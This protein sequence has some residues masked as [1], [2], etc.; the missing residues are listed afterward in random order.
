MPWAESRVVSGLADSWADIVF[1]QS[2]LGGALFLEH[3]T[4]G[5][6]DRRRGRA[7][8]GV[9]PV[10]R[11]LGRRVGPRLRLRPPFCPVRVVTMADVVVDN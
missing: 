1:R 8:R 10:A 11:F 5:I 6:P 9:G 4:I 2:T 3:L 7:R